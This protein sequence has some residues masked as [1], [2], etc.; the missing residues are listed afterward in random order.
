[1]KLKKLKKTNDENSNQK[2]RGIY[3]IK[4]AG[5]MEELTIGQCESRGFAN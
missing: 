4:P 5:K 1:M 3:V 2:P